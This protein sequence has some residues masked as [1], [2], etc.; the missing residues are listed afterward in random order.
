MVDELLVAVAQSLNLTCLEFFQLVLK[1]AN[2]ADPSPPL[3]SP[4]HLSVWRGRW[5]RVAMPVMHGGGPSIIKPEGFRILA[6]FSPFALVP[7][8]EEGA[9]PSECPPVG[10]LQAGFGGLRDT[11][12]GIVKTFQA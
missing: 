3:R 4:E 10:W 12:A 6:S 9:E 5:P 2:N 11:A 8:V 1:Q 7:P